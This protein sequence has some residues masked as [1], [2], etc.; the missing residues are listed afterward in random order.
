MTQVLSYISVTYPGLSLVIQL[1]PVSVQADLDER[2][3]HILSWSLLNWKLPS[4][5]LNINSKRL[6]H[7]HLYLIWNQPNLFNSKD[8][9]KFPPNRMRIG[10]HVRHTTNEKLHYGAHFCRIIIWKEVRSIPWYR[11][12]GHIKRA[13]SVKKHIHEVLGCMI[14]PTNYFLGHISGRIRCDCT[15]TI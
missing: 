5:Q 3:S 2:D 14:G 15:E 4:I 8:K 12:T 13:E 9:I 1:L 11:C 7:W 10:F 6:K